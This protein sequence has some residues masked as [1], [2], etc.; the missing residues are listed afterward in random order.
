M[1]LA[2]PLPQAQI[3][4]LSESNS[5][6]GSAL[7]TDNNEL[8]IVEKEIWFNWFLDVGVLLIGVFAC[9]LVIRNARYWKALVAI[10]S[11]LF[12]ANW[13][14]KYVI[15][16]LSLSPTE[17]Y[18]MTIR[19]AMGSQYPATA[20]FVVYTELV[21]PLFHVGVAAFILTASAVRKKWNAMH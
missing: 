8:T 16:S 20:I 5:S 1:Y 9:I 21:L 12:C 2:F 17:L 11:V 6:S 7:S 10:A 13:V 18:L 19:G 3:A 14:L 15:Y 4:Q